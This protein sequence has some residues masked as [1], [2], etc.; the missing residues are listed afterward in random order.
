MQSRTYPIVLIFSEVEDRRCIDLYHFFRRHHPEYQYLFLRKPPHPAWRWVYSKQ[1][2]W[3]NEQGYENALSWVRQH[4]HHRCVFLPFL[5]GDI[6]SVLDQQPWPSN[7]FAVLPKKDQF[8]LAND[9]LLFTEQFQAQGLTPKLYKP[10]DRNGGGE[11]VVKPRIGK[12]A[13]GL[14]VTTEPQ[15]YWSDS[16]VIQRR[17]PNGETVVGAFYLFNH[18]DCVASYLHER[19]RTYPTGGG[20]SAVAKVIENEGLSIKGR[21][22]LQSLQ[23]HGL[24]MIEFLWD[25]EQ[26]DFVAIECNPRLWGTVLLGEFAGYAL[27]ENYINLSLG[28]PFIHRS[29][30]PTAKLR[31]IFPYEW[32]YV[33]KKPFVR[34]RLLWGGEPNTCYINQSNMATWKVCLVVV[35]S[36]ADPK[37][38]KTLLKKLK[39]IK[40]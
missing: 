37:K 34:F 10:N 31:W 33:L 24:A 36:L 16:V 14:H 39:L 13:V 25:P 40:G 28:L 12:G 1:V 9:K 6:L 23:W 21:N 35:F 38:W 2:I 20:V 19:V 26:Q 11:W 5:E 15:K 17:L 18:G 22:M 32:M 29:P 30:N 7:F 27:V 4:Q 8:L 3:W